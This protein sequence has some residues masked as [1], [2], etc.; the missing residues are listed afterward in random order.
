VTCYH[1]TDM[2]QLEIPRQVRFR[3]GV[4]MDI[5]E[6]ITS[7]TTLTNDRESP[8]SDLAASPV[9]PDLLQNQ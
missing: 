7:I 3:E 2:L 5:Q 1:S 4:A 8:E 6:L 9:G